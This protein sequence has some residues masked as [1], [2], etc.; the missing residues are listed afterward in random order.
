MDGQ[1]V[2][3]RKFP[4]PYRAAFAICN[5]L[6]NTPSLNI[7]LTIMDYLNGN[8]E[9]PFGKGLALKWGTVCGFSI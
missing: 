3:L 7:Y 2:E 6:D 8:F 5:D 1:K 9:T 4:Y